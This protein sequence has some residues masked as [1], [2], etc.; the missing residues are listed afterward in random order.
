MDGRLHAV[1]FNWR[2]CHHYRCYGDRRAD[3]VS[4]KSISTSE[5]FSPALLWTGSYISAWGED[6]MMQSREE[7]GALCYWYHIA[8]LVCHSSAVDLYPWFG[9]QAFS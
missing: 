1:H 5:L 4:S 7:K 9:A 8:H 6:R 3:R 2:C